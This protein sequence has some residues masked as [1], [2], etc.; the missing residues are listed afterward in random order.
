MAFRW[1]SF[2]F[3][4]TEL[5]G[6]AAAETKSPEKD[7][8]QSHQFHTAQDHSFYVL[9]LVCIIAVTSWQQVSPNKKSFCRTVPD[10]GFF[11]RRPVL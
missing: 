6:T 4:G 11:Q 7:V 1:R 5:I 8:A 10:R 3:A 2:S 9:S